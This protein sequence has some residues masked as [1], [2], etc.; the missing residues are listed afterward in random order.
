MR[1]SIHLLSIFQFHLELYL[2]IVYYLVD[3]SVPVS[4]FTIINIIDIHSIMHGMINIHL[5]NIIINIR[6][7]ITWYVWYDKYT[8]G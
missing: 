1:Y 5:H 8:P 3:I 2:Q 6:I 7:I 4:R